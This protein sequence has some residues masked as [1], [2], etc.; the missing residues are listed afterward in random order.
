MSK[1]DDLVRRLRNRAE[2][3][4]GA[5]PVGAADGYGTHT[6][7]YY[8][9]AD[10][11]LDL[12]AIDAIERGAVQGV[13]TDETAKRADDALVSAASLI[14]ALCSDDISSVA[15]EE[16][17]F[18]RS[19]LTSTPPA[20]QAADTRHGAANGSLR[21]ERQATATPPAP[22]PDAGEEHPEDHCR[23]CGQSNPVWSAPNDLWNCVMGGSDGILCPRCFIDRAE[24]VGAAPEIWMVGPASGAEEIVSIVMRQ[25]VGE[26]G[27]PIGEG[28]CPRINWYTLRNELVAALSATP[29]PTPQPPAVEAEVVERCS[30]VETFGGTAMMP[31]EDGEWVRFTDLEAALKAKTDEIERLRRERDFEQSSRLTSEAQ[32]ATVI[33]N[34]ERRL[35]AAEASNKALRE[36]LEQIAYGKTILSAEAH[37]ADRRRARALLSET[38]GA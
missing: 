8:S 31:R 13:M 25:H 7:G 17:E 26:Y 33:S 23:C 15:I 29:S 18:A 21:G 2:T 1:N 24:M 9:T 30:M 12:E 37:A 20:P 32:L 4:N 6:L 35:E 38:G 3:M 22:A 36:G 5:C 14:K 34:L 10:R 11:A 16:I 28:G 19:A 27:K